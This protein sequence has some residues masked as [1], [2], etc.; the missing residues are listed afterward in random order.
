MTISRRD[1]LRSTFAAAA[2]LTA[3]GFLR[4]SYSNLPENRNILFIV[5][6]DLNDSVE[7]FGGHPQA[8]TPNIDSLAQRGTRFMNAA[9]NAPICSPSRPSMLTGL[10]PHTSGYYSSQSCEAAIPNAWNVITYEDGSQWLA[11]TSGTAWD[12]PRYRDAKTWIQYFSE[13]NYDVLLGGKIYH[14]YHK[15]WSDLE[16]NEGRVVYGPKPSWGPFP[17]KGSGRK[18]DNYTSMNFELSEKHPTTP[19]VGPIS[20]FTRLSDV[21]TINGYTGWYLYNHPYR[22]VSEEDR[23]P[24]PDERLAEWVEDF[25]AQR[26]AAGDNRPFFLN[27]GINRPHEPLVAPDKY[28]DMFPLDEIELAPGIKEG[29]LDD[30]AEFLYRDF[31]RNMKSTYHGFNFF[32][33]VN[34]NNALK[35]WTQAYLA[36]VAYADDMIGRMLTALENSPYRDNTMVV[37]TSDHGYH[38]GEKDYLFKNSAWERTARIPLVIAGPGVAAGAEC[39]SPVSL[40]DIYPTMIEYA[41]LPQNPHSHNIMDGHSLMPL[42]HNPQQELWAGPDV[43]LTMRSGQNLGNYDA[44]MPGF[45]KPQGQIYSVRSKYYRYIICPDGGEELY[46]HPTD[47]Y[48]WVNLASNS[49]YNN[50]KL[51]M[52][53]KAQQIV[54]CEIGQYYAANS[55]NPLPGAILHKD[56]FEGYQQGSINNYGGWTVSNGTDTQGAKV[57]AGGAFSPFAQGSQSLHYFRTQSNTT[58]HTAILTFPVPIVAEATVFKWDWMSTRTKGGVDNPIF[59]FTDGGTNIIRFGIHYATDKLR[60]FTVN[61]TIPAGTEE[62]VDGYKFQEAN[63]WYRFEV[64]AYFASNFYK[65]RIWRYGQNEPVI[66]VPEVMFAGT[67]S[68]ITDFQYRAFVESTTTLGNGHYLDNITAASVPIPKC[69]DQNHPYPTGDLNQDCRVDLEDIGIIA[70]GWLNCTAPE[71]K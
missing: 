38:M 7:G 46:Y 53:Q 59:A 47:P 1:F 36:C 69:G 14:N 66:N 56:D 17:Y 15:R 40:I 42:L 55:Y 67:A 62:N 64:T 29:D 71:C 10:Y 26:P 45:D 63:V 6:D 58:V 57:V 16:N 23:D 60:Y 41:G 61:G 33:N 30:C 68:T 24:M 27:V 13:Y 11:K 5:L 32:K 50:I 70:D 35:L 28:F 9:C 8:H 34:S 52:R 43:S 22:Y 25:L 18:P 3:P 51:S 44:F 54:G 65:L 39:Y 19:Y 2:A 48:E 49:A 31:A 37:I 20:F 4:S 12:M 21:P